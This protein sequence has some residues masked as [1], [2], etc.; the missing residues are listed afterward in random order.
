MR[1]KH[2][3]HQKTRVRN[4]GQSTPSC[5][6]YKLIMFKIKMCIYFANPNSLAHTTTV[7]HGMRSR[8]SCAFRTRSWPSRRAYQAVFRIQM[9]R[10][11]DRTSRHQ[12]ARLRR[13][14]RR[15]SWLLLREWDPGF[16]RIG[17]RRRVVRQRSIPR[18]LLAHTFLWE[19]HHNEKGNVGQGSKNGE[20]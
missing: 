16:R 1:A 9:S 4:C 2:A 14:R 6:I 15:R 18:V 8:Y 3:V 19:R 20:G 7:F 13:R 11:R 12:C 10:Y 5:N 17:S